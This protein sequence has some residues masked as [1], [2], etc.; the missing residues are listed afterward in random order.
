MSRSEHAIYGPHHHR[1]ASTVSRELQR[2][3]GNAQ[4]YRAQAAQ[5]HATACRHKPRVVRKLAHAAWW[6][7]VDRCLRVVWSPQQIA[8][9]L[10][11]LCPNDPGIHVSR[12]TIYK[13]IYLIPRGELRRTLVACLRQG[14]STRKPRTRGED[15]RGKIPDMQSIH[16]RP[17]DVEGRLIPGHWEG[18]L[19]KG[20]GNR[21][22]VGP[23]VERTTGCVALAKMSRGPCRGY[24]GEFQPSAG[25]HPRIPAQD[26]DLSAWSIATGQQR[27]HQWAAAAVSAQREESGRLEPRP[28]QRDCNEPQ[29]PPTQ[30]L[31]LAHIPGVL[32]RTDRSGSNPKRNHAVINRVAP[33]DLNR[34]H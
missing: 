23:L 2:V 15:R 28:A 31:W 16:V 20:A 25:A 33:R 10:R 19:I 27:E 18:D 32:R 17:P 8:H 22:S 21:S 3:S 5:H 29:H 12:E 1:S 6:A 14:R 13:A 26:P 24:F 11:H 30:A 9:I 4:G 7:I 34:P